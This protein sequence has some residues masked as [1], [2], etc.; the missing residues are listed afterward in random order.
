[1]CVNEVTYTMKLVKQGMERFLAL[2]M[3][4]ALLTTL[5]PA[6]AEDTEDAIDYGVVTANQV[7]VR[8][9]PG[10]SYDYWF[11]V[12]MGT[13]CRI[14]SATES[15]YKVE[16]AQP[17]N[18]ARIRTGYIS[19]EFF[20][21]MT[22]DEYITW[23][24]GGMVL[25]APTSPAATAQ[26][27]VAVGQGGFGSS[28]EFPFD[29]GMLTTPDPNADFSGPA[30]EEDP[31]NT[32]VPL[33]GATGEITAGDTNFRIAPSMDGGLIGKLSAGTVVEVLEIPSA[34]DTNHWYRIR[35]LGQE[36]YVQAPFVRMLT[37][38]STPTPASSG[39]GFARLKLDSAN[40]RDEPAGPTKAT[41]QGKGT[42]LQIV[43]P[44]KSK[45]GFLWYPVFYGVDLK[46]YYVRDDVVE[47]VSSLLPDASPAAT[48][49]PT[50]ASASP[51]GYVRTTQA[52]VNLRLQPSGEIITQVPK[53]T[54]LTCVGAAQRPM[55][56]EY[57]WYYVEYQSLRGYLRG[58]FVQVC[59]I[60]GGA[61][62]ASTPTLAPVATVAP[63]Q[64]VTY[65]Y[66]KLIKT[67]VNLRARPAGTSLG[68][69]ERDLI[70][71]VIGV[72]VISGQY[73]WYPVRTPDGRTGYV[74]SDCVTECNATG[75]APDATATP[76][77]GA[78]AVP[79]LST[80]G[81]I[82]ITQPSTKLR[83]AVE[84]ETI[85]LLANSSVWPL[86]GRAVVYRG[87]TWYP[88]RAEGYTGY[89]RGDCAYQLSAE[90]EL[91]WL[92][93]LGLPAATPAPSASLSN[94][95]Q[96]ILDYVNL[97]TSASQDA[98]APTQVR[99]GTVMLFTEQKQVGTTTWYRVNYDG[100][101][102]WVHGSCV[103]V[104]TAAEYQSWLTSH[105]SATA[106]PETGMGYVI[107]LAVGVNV[108]DVANGSNILA[109]LPKG[110]ILT[111][112][113]APVKAG[114]YTWYCVTTAGGVTGFV[115]SDLVE[116]CS[117]T[118]MPML[119]NAPVITAIPGAS[120]TATPSPAPQ[121][122]TYAT[123]R[124]GSKGTAVT[125]LVTELKNQGYYTGSV[126]SSYTSAVQAAV[127][128]FQQAKGL[129]VDGIAGSQ[130]Q[131]ALFG[132]VEPGTADY[133]DLSF[134]FYPAEKIN[135]FSGGIQQ[136]WPK[137]EN[138]KV[139]DVKTG[140]VWW[141]HRWAGSDHADVEPL[142]AAD[143]ARL[144]QIYGT[145]TAQEIAD[146]NLW[147]R[148]PCLVTIGNRT[149]ACSLF[150]M[151]HN[152]SGDTIPNN[153]M[154][155]QICIHFTGSKGHESGKVDSFHQEAIEYAYQNCP[156]GHK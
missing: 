90:Q 57:T 114:S 132:T 6:L 17:D 16:C 74:R 37:S 19:G 111:Y 65:G 32:T 27:T 93:G 39:Y 43:G 98:S 102:L 133:N 80:Y 77:P 70:L 116:P 97:R 151:P 56:S 9:G 33:E 78:T 36:G 73:A 35:Y 12:D 91:S 71:P 76:A 66:V 45:S 54:I 58:D 7:I 124:L 144:C 121:E 148:R 4:L 5:A 141:A 106:Q 3:I 46:T 67:G 142:T 140:I 20:R 63:T 137:G 52:G 100:R 147:Q 24:Q 83:D 22:E 117:S 152:P 110:T 88:V 101:T 126:T 115:R 87:V 109:S 145:S 31:V 150:G 81:Y 118:G 10:T 86:S 143:T 105:P 153:N 154:T 99:T 15:W 34:I 94:Y 130:T 28:T 14:L 30:Q 47:I 123:L 134:D 61:V 21:V 82:Q 55:G 135:W 26:P 107:T 42:L 8:K 155:G 11:R 72:R 13:V 96:T 146:K 127:R 103:K 79:Q 122:A 64:E 120:A 40:L 38:G 113:A 2:L 104:M 48:V 1:M 25:P 136:L 156:A 112:L 95:V 23:L 92:A 53:D 69:L 129:L 44:A 85:R 131:H 59:S 119:T 128:A 29:L 18:P 68:Q 75:G 108:R 139:Y 41:W 84:G 50:P 62:V 49:T 60:D 51:Y 125:R 138:V 149:F 89:V